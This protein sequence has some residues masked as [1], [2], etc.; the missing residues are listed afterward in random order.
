MGCLGVLVV[1][2][3]AIITV[4]LALLFGLLAMLDK[5]GT[6]TTYTV[7]KNGKIKKK[8]KGGAS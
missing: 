1:I 2:L 6:L 5:S 7:K 8:V 3:L 4:G